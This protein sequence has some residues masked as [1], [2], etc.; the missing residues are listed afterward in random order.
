MLISTVPLSTKFKSS[1]KI[2]YF[3][4]WRYFSDGLFKV[5]NTCENYE[6][7]LVLLEWSVRWKR[8]TVNWNGESSEPDIGW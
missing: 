1:W 8:L 4:L 6:A 5:L 2:T 7:E 3:W